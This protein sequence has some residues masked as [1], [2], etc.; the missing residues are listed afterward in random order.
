MCI[1]K[2]DSIFIFATCSSQV[3]K[4]MQR[5][6]VLGYDLKT[7]PVVKSDENNQFRKDETYIDCN[8][9]LEIPVDEFFGYLHNG[10]IHELQGTLDQ[11]SM[12]KIAEGIKAS[13]L[14]E[15]RIKVLF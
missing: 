11:T 3:E 15:N 1:K 8:N 7:Y 13:S 6:A 12:E 14:V 4:A 2:G 9:P 5:A 10:M